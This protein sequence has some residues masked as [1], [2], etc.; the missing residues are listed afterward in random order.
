M[1]QSLFNSMKEG[2]IIDTTGSQS[3]VKSP[4]TT[5]EPEDNK[6]VDQKTGT[7]NVSELPSEDVPE[8][9]YI[10]VS[11][12]TPFSFFPYQ[13]IGLAHLFLPFWFFLFL[14]SYFSSFYIFQQLF[15]LNSLPQTFVL[16][17]CINAICFDFVSVWKAVMQLFSCCRE[18][19][20]HVYC[21]LFDQ[22]S[23]SFSCFYNKIILMMVKCNNESKMICNLT[24]MLDKINVMSKGNKSSLHQFS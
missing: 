9:V 3:P 6:S 14:Q 2:E 1:K 22:H 4:E 12:V 10:H 23:F 21:L 16:V 19:F 5:K 18:S 15:P 20:L 8:K 11:C 17:F 7:P 13:Q 24:C